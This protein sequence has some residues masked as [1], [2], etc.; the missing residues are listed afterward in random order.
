VRYSRFDAER[1]RRQLAKR[2]KK[3]IPPQPSEFETGAMRYSRTDPDRCFASSS[4]FKLSVFSDQEP[5]ARELRKGL[6]VERAPIFLPKPAR[7]QLENAASAG[8]CVH[9]LVLISL[10]S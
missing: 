9:M 5:E 3:K 8:E 6:V 10:F 4:S 1:A 2:R 7:E